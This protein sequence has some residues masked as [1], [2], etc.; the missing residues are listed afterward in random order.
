MSVAPPTAHLVRAR[1]GVAA[2]VRAGQEV[3]IVDV[4]GGQV[5]DFFA[6][7]AAD[8][9]EYLSA[10]HTRAFTSRVFPAIGQSF[11]SSQRRPMLDVVA[12]TSPGFHD[13]LVAACDPARYRQ[14]GVTS[15][16]AS[17]AENL[18]EALGAVGVRPTHV[19]Q[20]FN[21]F[22]RTPATVDGSIV[23]LPAETKAGDSFVMR[24]CMDLVVA[25]SACPSE[26]SG[27]NAGPLSDLELVVGG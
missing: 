3:T 7:A 26:L 23:W 22:M 2:T 20:P 11:L 17:C 18:V 14:L 10:S 8:P 1:T 24:A 4:A 12:D 6:F 9:S 19:P 16:H 21:V 27:I 25:L 13:L 15:W 5:G